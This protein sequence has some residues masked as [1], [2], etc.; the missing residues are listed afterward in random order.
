ML[1]FVRMTLQGSIWECRCDCGTVDEW[2]LGALC[3]GNTKS[4]GCLQSEIASR[5]LKK[6][7]SHSIKHGNSRRKKWSGAYRSWSAM[8]TRCENPKSKSYSYYG[9]RGI[10]VCEEW[11][12]FE[13][14]LRD[15]GD[16]PEGLTLDRIDNNLPYSKANCRWAS[17]L[18]QS[19]N[20]RPYK[21]ST[22]SP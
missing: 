18:E 12:Q 11:H 1:R 20:R 10:T 7:H 22:I 3:S 21:K 9:E 17:R 2:K 13:N 14:F 16:R 5:N 4:C 8:L 6:I 15:M 19:R